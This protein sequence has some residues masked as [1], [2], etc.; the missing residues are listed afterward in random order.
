MKLSSN[1]MRNLMRSPGILRFVKF[2]IVGGSGIL[3]NMGFLWLFTEVF[4][5]YYLVSSVLAIFLAIINNFIWNDLW[6]WA[7]RGKP[8]IRAY[9]NR[10]FKFFI[11][12]SIAGYAGNLGILWV[13]TH[14]LQLHYL[15][16]NLIGIGV[17]TVVNYFLNNWWTFKSSHGG[18]KDDEK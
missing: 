12:S 17:G 8:G 11:V 2:G 6:T 5:I 3:V 9:A 1:A 10:F 18:D 14:F 7:D 15:I 13:F 4:G 16:S